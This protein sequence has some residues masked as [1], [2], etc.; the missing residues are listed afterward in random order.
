MGEDLNRMTTAPGRGSEMEI[1]EPEN[2]WDGAA[3]QIYIETNRYRGGVYQIG[4]D[5]V[6]DKHYFR[7][8]PAAVDAETPSEW[9]AWGVFPPEA[10]PPEAGRDAGDVP[11]AGRDHRH[12][13]SG[14]RRR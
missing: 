14:V 1:F 8:L 6:A 3:G 9:G 11:E 12:G 13:A 10:P 5:P 2:A 4:Y 7:S